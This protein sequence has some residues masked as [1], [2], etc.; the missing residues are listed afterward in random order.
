MS[1]QI[2]FLSLSNSTIGST[3]NFH[4]NVCELI[5]KATPA[6]LHVE[7]L[8]P[9]YKS[10]AGSLAGIVN[11]RTAFVSTEALKN[12][13]KRR[14]NAC[15]TIINAMNAFKRS[16]VQ[17]KQEAAS[18]LAPQL[19]PYKGIGHH[20]YSKQTA[21]LRGMLEVLGY[22][23]NVE[24]VKALGLEDDVEALRAAAA[25][26]ERLFAQR[27]A[28]MSARLGEKQLDSATVIK[29]VNARYAEIAQVVNAYA[30]VSPTDGINAF[31]RELNGYIAVYARINGSSSSSSGGAA[32]PAE[33]TDPT[34]PAE[35]TDPGTG[36][37]G[38]PDEI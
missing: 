36:G 20:E 23:A 2:V 3:S 24:A 6:A 32:G 8:F 5:E 19:A 9:G 34:E 27:A 12:A 10:A 1:E 7:H 11:R 4:T 21:E 15:G 31:I 37:G 38:S 28:E 33:P 30:I 22:E 18:L 35:P 17:A 14:D 13:D 16:L 26:F 29:D 25:E